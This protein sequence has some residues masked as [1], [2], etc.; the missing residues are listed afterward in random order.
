[1]ILLG[2]QARWA[3]LKLIMFLVPATL[4]FRNFWTYPGPQELNQFHHFVK[5]LAV[6]GAI[7]RILG[8]GSGPLNLKQAESA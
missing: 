5:N 4:Q 2:W 3:A 8:M 6:L 7:F 1:M